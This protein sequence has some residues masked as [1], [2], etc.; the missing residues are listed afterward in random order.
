MNNEFTK[1]LITSLVALSIISI[2]IILGN[3][4]FLILLLFILLTSSYEWNKL[5]NNLLIFICGSFFLIISL[6]SAYILRNEN[7]FFFIF[8]LGISIFSDI[9][10]YFFGKTFKGPRLTKISPNK[11]YSGMFGSYLTSFLFSIVYL[12]LIDGHLDID[13]NLIFIFVLLI[14]SINQMGDLIISYFK[15]QNKIKDTGK[16]LPGH[17]GILDRI[18]GIIFSIPFG[19]LL[20]VSL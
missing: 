1:R 20:F 14:S 5:T 11:T 10:G 15:R 19:H 7:L 17:G 9:G 13:S 8:I 6:I 4:S 18:D 2:C 16:I 3:V 12:S